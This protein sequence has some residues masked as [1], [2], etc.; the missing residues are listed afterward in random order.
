MWFQSDNLSA[1]AVVSWNG[2]DLVRQTHFTSPALKP[3]SPI[4][5]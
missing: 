4:F 5:S 2:S 1:N 3:V